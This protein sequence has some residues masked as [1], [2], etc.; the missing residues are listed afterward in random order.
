MNT[1]LILCDDDN[2]TAIKI[3]KKSL[4]V[5][6]YFQTLFT[7][8]NETDTDIINITV[9]N[10]IVSRDII[11]S[12]LYN[13]T[14]VNATLFS[15]W[16]YYLQCII[17]FDYFNLDFDVSL[18]KKLK[19]PEREFHQLINVAENVGINSDFINYIIENMPDYFDMSIM[20]H[21]LL[22]NIKNNLEPEYLTCIFDDYI[23]TYNINTHTYD[24][25][26]F[27]IQSLGLDIIY[28]GANKVF[29]IN[30]EESL[31]ISD[32]NGNL[33]K[34]CKNGDKYEYER[35]HKLPG[36]FIK[37]INRKDLNYYSENDLPN[38][39]VIMSIDHECLGYYNRK[40][41]LFLTQ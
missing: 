29:Y 21:N 26:S 34:F 14:L 20:S 7:K 39:E 19:V 13:T 8:F 28:K 25:Q 24:I 33:H 36:E 9:P 40:T 37:I 30:D 23:S 1:T 17:C 32:Y 3:H 6:P 22:K 31:L 2:K 5:Y 4:Y 15:D 16:E 38:V 18:L 27:Y 10:A 11:V 41:L 12:L 35:S